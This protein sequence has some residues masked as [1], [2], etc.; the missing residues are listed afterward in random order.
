MVEDNKAKSIWHH[1]NHDDGN[2]KF[3]PISYV[4]SGLAEKLNEKIQQFIE[5]LSITKDLNYEFEITN[6][7]VSEEGYFLTSHGHGG[8]DFE[9]CRCYSC[10][11][12]K[13]NIQPQHS[14]IQ[15]HLL[16]SVE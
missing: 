9:K 1:S 15:I 8:D 2:P 14:I 10:N 5:T 12:I 4:E 11:M 16:I 6:Y 13:S 7:T 3:K